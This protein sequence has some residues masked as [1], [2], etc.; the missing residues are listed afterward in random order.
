MFPDARR[1]IY[2]VQVGFEFDSAVYLPY[3]AGTIIA[4]CRADADVRERYEFRDI[5]FRREKLDD[6]LGRIKDPYIAAFSCSTWN[7]EYNKALARRVKQKY[8]DCTVV[9]G[10]HSVAESGEMIETEDYIDFLMFGEGEQVFASLLKNIDTDPDRVDNIAFRRDG[11]IVRTPR[12][13]YNDIS[14]YP[15]PYLSGL[16]DELIEKYPGQEFLSVLETNR[17]CPYSCAY[18]DWCAGKKMRFFPLEKIFG[19]IEWLAK[20]R[21]AY[22]FCADSNFG[23]FERDYEIAQYLVETKKKYGYPEVFRPCYEKNSAERVFRICHLLNSVG[24]DKG[25]TMA[26]QTLSPEALKNI[27]RKNLTMEHFSELMKKYN[28]AGI[29]TYSELILGLPGETKESFCHGICRLLENGQ[30]RS[31][32]VYHCEVLPNSE[33]AMPEYIA[34]HGIEIMKVAF[35]HIHSAIKA[36]EEVQEYS[37]LVRSTATLSRDDWVYSNLFSVCVQCFHSLGLL[38]F[39]AVYLYA[40]NRTSYYDFYTSLLDFILSSGGRLKTLFEGFR[41]KYETSLKGD[42]NY[43]NELFGNVTWFFEEGAFL[44]A[45]TDLESLYEELG[46][47]LKALPVDADVYP[48]LLAFQKTMI[49]KPGGGNTVLRTGYDLY[50]CFETYFAEGK[51]ELKKKGT[52]M[53]VTPGHGFADIATYAKETVWFGRRRGMTLW[54]SSEISVKEGDRD[55][56]G[57]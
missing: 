41:A 22:C 56:E 34:K 48:D 43:H 44:E 35:N 17:G 52:V 26:Y 28:E 8:P 16:F 19:E 29:P 36:T 1:N 23:M 13:Y 42:W 4:Y 3:A 33:L 21:I 45:V 46:P 5:I 7:V 47:F 53:T 15:S 55:S 9:F 18:C 39:F 10:G 14:G 51:Y 6:A 31:V 32:S 37:Y 57:D 24:M 12:A 49:R 20:H 11:E 25:A 50:N 38:R 40:E 2:F 54:Q 27:G 30:H